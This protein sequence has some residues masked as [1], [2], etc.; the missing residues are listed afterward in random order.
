MPVAAARRPAQPPV[1]HGKSVWTPPA[2]APPRVC[3]APAGRAPAD[4]RRESPRQA[5][6]VGSVFPRFAQ[7]T[8]RFR[9]RPI[10]SAQAHGYSTDGACGWRGYADAHA[11]PPHAFP[12]QPGQHASTSGHSRAATRAR[13]RESAASA[14]PVRLVWV[15]MK[16]LP[17]MHRWAAVELTN[18]LARWKPAAVASASDVIPSDIMCKLSG[19]MAGR[20]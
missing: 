4:L 9:T 8:M 15:R 16:L 10:E 13:R 2:T 18:I 12:T 19:C 17:E 20:K 7:H 5:R 11:R 1:K 14:P 3:A 6:V